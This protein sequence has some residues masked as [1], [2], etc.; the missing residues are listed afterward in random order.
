V[1]GITT[2]CASI[3]SVHSTHSH[4]AR[5][6][7]DSHADTCSF[8]NQAYI[9]H[10]TGDTISVTGFI[11]LLGTVKKVPI[12][13]DTVAYDDPDTYTTSVLFFHQSLYFLTSWTSTCFAHLKCNA[14]K[15][16]STMYH[17]YIFHSTNAPT[18]TIQL[19]PHHHTT[20]TS[21]YILAGQLHTL[22]RG[23]RQT[24]KSQVSITASMFT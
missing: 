17:Y 11:D 20:H 14:I 13:T 16:L 9:V 4:G 6:E 24:M 15:S 1:S 19:C 10:D 18:R 23:S 2:L 8:G 3:S 21:P 12:V 5:A 7:L 22:K